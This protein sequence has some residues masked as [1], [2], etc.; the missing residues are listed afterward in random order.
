LKAAETLSAQI[1]VLDVLVNNAGLSS[2]DGVNN[3]LTEPIDEMKAMYEVNVFGPVRTTRAFVELLKKSKAGR[4]VNVGSSMG[5]LIRITDKSHFLFPFVMNGYSSSKS[6]LSALSIGFSKTLAEF[7]I[8]VNVAD[9]GMTPTDL[10]GHNGTDTIE[11]AAQPIIFL[12]TL[13]DDGPTGSFYSKDGVV[14]W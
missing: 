6:A 9:P 14:A 4:V 1:S 5:S 8:K 3:A 7:N 12:S 13:P 2:Y 10:N 11:Q